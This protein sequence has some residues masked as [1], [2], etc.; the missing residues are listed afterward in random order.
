MTIWKCP[1][2]GCTKIKTYHWQAVH[3]EY[4]LDAPE[5]MDGWDFR[6]NTPG[7]EPDILMS[8]CCKHCAREL[9]DD[10]LALIAKSIGGLVLSGHPRLPIN[11]NDIKGY[12]V[13]NPEHFEG[14]PVVLGDNPWVWPDY[15]GQAQEMFRRATVNDNEHLYVSMV[16]EVIDFTRIAGKYVFCEDCGDVYDSNLNKCPECEA[17]A[18]MVEADPG[19][20]YKGGNNDQG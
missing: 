7:H 20:Q 3:G 14:T 15:E 8:A 9:T 12:V 10:E 17:W 19:N 1:E 13:V 11:P 2:C 6:Y 16:L 18:E 5:E 4:E